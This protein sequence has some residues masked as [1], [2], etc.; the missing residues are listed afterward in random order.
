M[1]ASVGPAVR[2]VAPTLLR[3]GPIARTYSV[4]RGLPWP[5]ALGRH[6]KY[7]HR[8]SGQI[9]TC[10]AGRGRRPTVSTWGVGSG[11]RPAVR[12]PRVVLMGDELAGH[13]V[14]LCHV[15]QV[16]MNPLLRDLVRG[17][18]LGP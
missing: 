15:G 4:L 9:E 1:L 16:L 7:R 10:A 14:R 6:T 12:P 3:R 2:R 5:A 8:G 13:V 17:L 18:C 11:G